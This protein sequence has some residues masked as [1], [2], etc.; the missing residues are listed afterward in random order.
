MG[1][2]AAT[3]LRAGA[4]LVFFY[5]LHFPA[6]VCS[7]LGCAG[8]AR[9]HGCSGGL[10]LSARCPQLTF[11]FLKLMSR[12]SCSPFPCPFSHPGAG[13]GAGKASS[14]ADMGGD[15]K[16]QLFSEQVKMEQAPPEVS[17]ASAIP[18]FHFGGT[19][20]AQGRTHPRSFPFWGCPWRSGFHR[21]RAK[22]ERGGCSA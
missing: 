4:F 14:R 17:P 18:V 19:G 16:K 2:Q 21:I 13:T 9:G 15:P 8:T 22:N 10:S 5:Y 7:L 11:L 20:E 1:T 12:H 6:T 3:Y